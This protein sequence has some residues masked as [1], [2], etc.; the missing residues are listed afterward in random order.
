MPNKEEWG[1][2]ICVGKRRTAGWL[3]GGNLGSQGYVWNKF[4]NFIKTIFKYIFNSLWGY[5]NAIRR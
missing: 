1:F 3:L 5:L 2:P 4:R